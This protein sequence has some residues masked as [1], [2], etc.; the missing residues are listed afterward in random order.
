M[1]LDQ[2]QRLSMLRERAPEYLH[3][4]L[5]N[6]TREYPNMP[7][8]IATG[9]GPYPTHREFHPAFYGCFDWHSCVEMHWVVVRLLRLFPDAVPAQ[10]ARATLDELLT[11]ENVAAEINFFS[12]PNHRSLERPYGW[13][14]LLTLSQELE[15]WDDA[16]GKQW[17]SIVR[18]LA[19]LLATNLAN[20][21]PNLT[22]P[23]RTG[24]HPNTAFALS[25]SY[26]WAT[27]R[28]A[29]GDD[30]LLTAIRT[31]APRWFLN[32]VDYPAHFEPSGSD[33]LSPALTEAELMSRLL[34]A[35][36]FPGWLERFLP[37]LADGQPASL[38]QPAT[39]SDVTDGQIAHLHGLNL[40]RAWAF[41][42]LADRL[43]PH[44]AR[45]NPLREAAERHAAAALPYVVGTGYMVE[46]WL[47]AY[48][49]LLLSS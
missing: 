1:P 4:A 25:R 18:P 41:I 10:Q 28:A 24:V 19:E 20:W 27:R 5:T 38:F 40:S 21:L 7:H 32:D 2:H 14:W 48:A 29:K 47:A 17:A 6:I 33:F 23:Q 43:A 46:H 12:N 45:I 22:Y 9:P 49:T 11:T 15:T 37:G 31:A 35:P 3:V 39:V 30:R 44:D 36:E 8:F 34:P 16:N 42:V 26:D 13:G